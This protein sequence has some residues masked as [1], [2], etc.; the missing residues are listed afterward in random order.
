MD[1]VHTPQ[2]HKFAVILNKKLD[3][4]VALN[5]ASHL[6]AA[7]ANKAVASQRELMQF[8]DYFDADGSQHPVSAL[9]LIVLRADN[10]N[11]IR[12]ACQAAKEAGLL[13]VDFIESMTGGTA[14]EQQERT[15]S[16]SENDLNYYGV[17]MF[18]EVEILRD[19]TSKFS[20]WR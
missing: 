4:G 2:T 3:T 10:S 7:L 13:C 1:T 20:L 14:A 6:M 9:S 5:A 15:A 17:A 12:T 19:I 11:K 16:L 8:V 18:G